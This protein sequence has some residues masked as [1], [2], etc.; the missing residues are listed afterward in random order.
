MPSLENW[1]GGL[2]SLIQLANS[3]HTPC[4]GH[5]MSQRTVQTR[6]RAAGKGKRNPDSMERKMLPGMAN[7][8]RLKLKAK[9]SL[10]NLNSHLRTYMHIHVR[11]TACSMVLVQCKDT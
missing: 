3:P 7:V 9:K 11:V 10:K 8:W 1:G 4:I 5:T 2:K 6:R